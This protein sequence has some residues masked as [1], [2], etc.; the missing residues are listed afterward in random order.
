MAVMQGEA[1]WAG[2]R[3]KSVPM[4][5]PPRGLR[6][7]FP[8]SLLIASLACSLSLGLPA[9]LRADARSAYLLRLLRS[10]SN[11]RVRAQAALT[12]GGM[13]GEAVRRGLEAALRDEHPAVRTAAAA[14]LAKLADP[15]A[16][17]ALRAAERRERHRATRAVMKR[18]MRRLA[19]LPRRGRR[20]GG[21]G[22]RG[23]PDTGPAPPSAPYLLLVSVGTSRARGAGERERRWLAEAMHRELRALGAEVMDASS[24]ARAMREE[25]RRARDRGARTY[26]VDGSL[27]E[28]KE[29]ERGMHAVVSVVLNT[30][31]GRAIRAM[32]RGAAT[33]PGARDEAARKLA[34]EGAARGALRRIRRALQEADARGGG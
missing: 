9:V 12:L 27:V 34:I 25:Q 24:N 4:T 5:A 23:R 16:L 30:H 29:T 13:R 7:K 17:A 3:L 19:S 15:A 26:R 18:S 31:P 21:R 33:V 1:C 11:F 28:V 10:S 8:H 2:G 22:S 6:A 14:S 20:E 32:M